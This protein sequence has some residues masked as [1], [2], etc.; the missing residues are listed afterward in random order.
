MNNTLY[1]KN[2]ILALC[3]F[4]GALLMDFLFFNNPLTHGAIFHLA[5][6]SFVA[7]AIIDIVLIL[8]AK[9]RRSFVPSL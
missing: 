9:I 6:S 4:L 8:V 5:G 1:F 3:I 7:L 2:P